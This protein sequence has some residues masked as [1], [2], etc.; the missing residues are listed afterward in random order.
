M[1]TIHRSHLQTPFFSGILHISISTLVT[2]ILPL[3]ELLDRASLPFFVSKT[4]SLL[5]SLYWVGAG[6]ERQHFLAQIRD[7]IWKSAKV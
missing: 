1:L 7:N 6:K 3:P 4:V 5:G 2:S